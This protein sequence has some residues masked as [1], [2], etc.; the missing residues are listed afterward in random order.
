MLP[1]PATAVIVPLPQLP[2]NPFGVAT[3]TPAGKVSV[4]ATPLSATFVFGLLIWNVSVLLVFSGM[5]VGLNDL[6]IVGGEATVSVAVLLVAPVPPLVELTA[7]VVFE[8]VP[9]SVPVTFTTMVQVFPG[10]AMVPLLRLMLVELA[11]AVTVPPQLLVTPGVLATCN[12]FV[13]V[14]LNAIPFSAVELA[15]GLVMVNVTVV[16]PLSGILAAPNALLIVGGATTVS[17]AVLLVVPVPPSVELIAPVVL[18]LLPAV[19]PVTFTE[20]VQVDPA[21]G[22][23]VSVP[24]DRVM[25]L[26]P[27]VAVTVPA[28]QAPVNPLGVATTT[29]A[30]KLSVNAT[31]LKAL[32]VFG[33]TM[34]KDSVLVPFSGILVGLKLL[35]IVGGATTVRVAVLLATPVPPSVELIAPVVLLLTPA[36]VPVTFTENVQVDPAPGDMVNVPPAR[37][38]LPLPATAVIVPLPQLPVKPFG[39]ATTTPAGRVSVNAIP[40]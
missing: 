31:A 33:L 20:N 3:T 27:A 38:M 19:V 1:L 11:T 14:S 16:V 25:V 9:D 2:V 8:T 34:V 15:A 24:P 4:N 5:L 30:G 17:V 13:S 12:P 26:L 36:V 7:P 10:V 6:V 21:A 40:L 39:V 18:L 32:A 29:P 23:A 22:D 37:L 35:L 28:P